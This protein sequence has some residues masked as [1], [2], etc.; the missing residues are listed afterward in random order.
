MNVLQLQWPINMKS[1]THVSMLICLATRAAHLHTGPTLLTTCVLPCA[2]MA[3]LLTKPSTYV[4][5]NVLQGNM[6]ITSIVYAKLHAHLH[7]KNTD[8]RSVESGHVLNIAL[9][10]TML[11]TVPIIVSCHAPVLQM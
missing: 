9:T 4:S 11:I 2:P 5:S 1:I 3:T 8:Y 6:L 10:L 7:P